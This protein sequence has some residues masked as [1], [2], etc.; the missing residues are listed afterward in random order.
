M[1]YPSLSSFFLFLTGRPEG[2]QQAVA[3]KTHQQ[4]MTISVEN[5]GGVFGSVDRGEIE[6][7][8]VRLAIM[9]AG[10]FEPGHLVVGRK[11]CRLLGVSEKVAET[12]ANLW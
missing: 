7:G 6:H 11:I 4:L 5:V 10:E 8:H 3:Y 9:V 1:N 12:G 2:F